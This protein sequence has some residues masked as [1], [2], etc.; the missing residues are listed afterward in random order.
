L[1][2]I[3]FQ[4]IPLKKI[5]LDGTSLLSTEFFRIGLYEDPQLSLHWQ[6]AMS[7]TSIDINFSRAPD[8]THSHFIRATAKHTRRRPGRRLIKWEYES[9]FHL[10]PESD[11][12]TLKWFGA[13]NDRLVG[14]HLPGFPGTRMCNFTDTVS[15]LST[16][17]LHLETT[18]LSPMDL[19]V[20]GLK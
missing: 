13:G 9:V 4:D 2:Y 5:F 6:L 18:I 3:D 7:I 14:P 15:M 10:Q 16:E 20:T 12:Y 17:L 8:V 11:T 1:K 19:L